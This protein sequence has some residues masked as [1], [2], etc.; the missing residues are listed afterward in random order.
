LRAGELMPWGMI[1]RE[2]QGGGQGQPRPDWR[3]RPGRSSRRVGDAVLAT[4]VTNDILCGPCAPGVNVG[5]TL[6]NRLDRVLAFLVGLVFD[7]PVDESFKERKTGK[8]TAATA[9]DGAATSHSSAQERRRSQLIGRRGVIGDR[10]RA[11]GEKSGPSE[12]GAARSAQGIA[13]WVCGNG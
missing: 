11:L 12:P 1:P 13:D 4:E 8:C 5:K 2:W 3:S 9:L 10:F 7:F 6:L